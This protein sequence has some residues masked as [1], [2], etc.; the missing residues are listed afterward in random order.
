[1]ASLSS[2]PKNQQEPYGVMDSSSADRSSSRMAD[3]R[4]S[5]IDKYR[6]YSFGEFDRLKCV[7]RSHSLISFL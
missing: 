3:T 1:M 5:D 2:S 6:L 7:R 4:W